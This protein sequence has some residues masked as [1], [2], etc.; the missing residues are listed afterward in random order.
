M[1]TAKE[2]WRVR[3][4]KYIENNYHH[5]YKNFEAI[6]LFMLSAYCLAD[7]TTLKTDIAFFFSSL[8]NSSINSW[9]VFKKIF[10]SYP[11]YLI[12]LMLSISIVITRKVSKETKTIED[13][14]K[15]LKLDL[16][17][18]ETKFDETKS[19]LNEAEEAI[20]TIKA[21]S[22]V[23]TYNYNSKFL[24]FIFNQLKLTSTDR[25]SLYLHNT[26][27]FVL[28]ARYSSNSAFHSN[29]RSEF[30]DN[31][32]VIGQSWTT[33]KPI[34]MAFSENEEEYFDQHLKQGFTKQIIKKFTMKSRL[35]VAVPI[36]KNSF[37]KHGVLLIEST[38]AN[39]LTENL[40]ND[41]MIYSDVMLHLLSCYE[42]DLNACQST[43]GENENKSK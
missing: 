25:I 6:I 34:K 29:H 35:L 1:T 36:K 14:N 3:A 11:L 27:H 28:A 40:T 13:E 37:D 32:G 5:L 4:V 8:N 43:G 2:S 18:K 42:V 22:I 17:K 38:D 39:G 19:Q 20:Y 24:C 41:I 12:L 26:S 21:D 7:F 9:L 31:Q 10:S 15:T 23:K 16:Q 30:P 33:D